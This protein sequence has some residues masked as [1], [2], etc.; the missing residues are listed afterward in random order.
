MV[1]W[2]EIERRI[3]LEIPRHGVRRRTVTNSLEPRRRTVINSL[4]LRSRTSQ[5]N[6][7]SHEQQEFRCIVYHVRMEDESTKDQTEIRQ[8][9]F[10]LGSEVF[11]L[12]KYRIQTQ[13][14]VKDVP[15]RKHSRPW[16]APFPPKRQSNIRIDAHRPSSI[17][18][19][20][21]PYYYA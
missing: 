10:H 3:E 12:P 16:D 19:Y 1:H 17:A 6:T 8:H 18:K 5:M 20:S 14:K 13:E 4:E 7:S 15:R 9:L 2:D 21:V 11:S